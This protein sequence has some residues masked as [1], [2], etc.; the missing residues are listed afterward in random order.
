MKATERRCSVCNKVKST[1][2]F[3]KNSYRASGR[4]SWCI[5]CSRKAG[6]TKPRTVKRTRVCRACGVRKRI[7]EFCSDKRLVSGYGTRCRECY[8]AQRERTR[9]REA[10]W[11]R[12]RRRRVSAINREWVWNFLVSHPCV[13]CGEVD[14]VVLDFDHKDGT[15]KNRN[16]GVARLMGNHAS[17]EVIIAEV[18]KCQ[19]RCANCHR[20]LTAK[21]LGWWRAMRQEKK[22]C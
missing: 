6:K 14:P 18:Q 16:S 20:K 1:R 8:E 15:K 12:N 4:T 22:P 3:W 7:G 13:D 19:V 11:T 10:E 9:Q 21:K 17:L 2:L 5:S